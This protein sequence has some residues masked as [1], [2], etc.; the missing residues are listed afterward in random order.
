MTVLAPADGHQLA[1]MLEFAVDMEGPV[2]IRY[3]RGSSAGNH[4]RLR[5]FKGS[6]SVISTGKDITI[7]AVGAML[8]EALAASEKLKAS[9]FDTGVINVA[10]V[11]P[12]DTSWSNLDTKLVI[13]IEDN[14]LSG[15]FGESFTS[16]YHDS[17]FDIINIAIPDK[18]VSH[19]DIPSLRR[20]CGI[21]AGSIVRKAEEY[22]ERKA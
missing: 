19:G 9:G 15:G 12:L 10:V 8:D 5:K 20:E 18:F 7:L 13:T 16:A 14:V 21:D 22:F 17:D 4:L 3:P 2:A 1:E 6:N 11:K